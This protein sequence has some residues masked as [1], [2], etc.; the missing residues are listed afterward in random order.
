MSIRWG[1]FGAAALLALVLGLA[2][3]SRIRQTWMDEAL[4]RELSKSEVHALMP[5]V[6]ADRARVALGR[7]LFYDP[8]LSGNKDVSCATCHDPKQAFGDGLTLSIGTGGTGR[9]PDRKLGVGRRFIGRNAPSLLNKATPGWHSMFWDGRVE[10]SPKEGFT[11]MNGGF[12]LPFGVDCLLAAQALFP[13]A[14]RDEMRGHPGD[15]TVDG[16]PNELARIDTNKAMP[17]LWIAIMKRLMAVPE[18]R[19]LFRAAYPE[20]KAD[21][22]GMQHVLNALAAYE[23][24]VTTYFDTPF[25]RYLIGKDSALTP[26][27]KRG[28]LLFYGKAGCDDCHTGNL[29]SDQKF[30]NL[31]VPQIGPGGGCL[32]CHAPKHNETVEPGGVPLGK[33]DFGRYVTSRKDEDRF[34]FRTPTLRNVELTG[35]YMHDGVF[36]T[37]EEVVAHHSNPQASLESFQW[38][39]QELKMETEHR[40]EMLK[41]L[42]ALAKPKNLTP[43]EQKDL[44][45]FLKALTDERAHNLEGLIPPSVPSGL[46][47]LP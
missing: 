30:H 9:G 23:I 37:L 20:I 29:F 35:P 40:Q 45:E 10:G 33:Q 18:Y 44:V 5:P 41:K 19:E 26:A 36:T 25:D 27:A 42:D 12:Q 8:I 4:G 2:G 31:A 6:P 21:Q 38:D 13:I 46:K 1:L 11:G 39:N 22:F 17:A 24:D 14:S 16:Q 34:A 47:V 7:A 3:W 43:D 15:K 32:E 28:A